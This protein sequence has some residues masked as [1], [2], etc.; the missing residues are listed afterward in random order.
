MRADAPVP[1]TRRGEFLEAEGP[2]HSVLVTLQ[3]NSCQFEPCT[4]TLQ[5]YISHFFTTNYRTVED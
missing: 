5:E 2:T 1:A 4:Y 3:S